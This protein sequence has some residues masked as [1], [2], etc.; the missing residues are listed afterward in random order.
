MEDGYLMDAFKLH[1]KISTSVLAGALTGIL[2]AELG[3]WGV[4]IDATEGA[5]LTLVLSFIAG[6]FTPST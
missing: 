1:P 4:P 3:R 5:H 6:Y 2:I